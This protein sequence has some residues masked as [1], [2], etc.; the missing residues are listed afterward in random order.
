M[1]SA[2][3]LA[4]L[5]S[6]AEAMAAADPVAAMSWS[7]WQRDVLTD[8]H[9]FIAVRA[10]NQIGKT[11]LAAA[12]I[13]MEI[14]G[15]NPFRPPRHRGPL[16]ILLCSESYEQM[17]REGGVLEKLWEMLPKDEIDPKVS[18][19]RGKG[20][21]GVKYP[22]IRFI[23]GP[24]AGSVI[25][26]FRYEQGARKLAGSTLHGIVLDEPCPADIY[27]EAVP[28]LRQH[29]G[30]ML[31]TFTPTPDM[32]DQT[33]LRRLI[34]A[35]AVREHHIELTEAAC[36]PQG[37]ARPFQ[38]QA[39]IDAFAAHLEAHQVLLRVKAAWETIDPERYLTAW[40]EACVD[41]FE[42]RDLPPGALVGVGVDHGIQAGKQRA[43]LLVCADVETDAP[44][45]WLVDE[46]GSDD[47]T[48]TEQDAAAIKHMLD[49]HGL[50]YDDVDLW[51]G[52]R[53]AQDAHQ[54]KHKNNAALMRA[55]LRL[56]GRTADHP[57]AR[58]LATPKKWD[59]SVSDGFTFMNKA[60]KDARWRVH[61][62]CLMFRHAAATWRKA[63]MD[64]LK[65][66]LDPARYVMQHAVR[67]EVKIPALRA[68]Y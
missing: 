30:W 54:I 1:R 43:C 10:A 21:M 20:L 42:I 44:R 18:F 22:A 23:S 61:P 27:G 15:T 19:I 29:Q 52:D 36:W 9:R 51:V 6:E 2:L 50:D 28:R 37:Y 41:P 53:S 65:D 55:I 32:P 68:G 5:F 40:G 17:S 4:D 16:N 24:G 34:K 25:R 59:R 48:T 45:F 56:Y 49:R 38:S 63:Q 26:L 62:R 66:C 12:M 33:Y 14:R 13:I 35:G 31:I 7:A 60:M 8:L 46:A 47:P 67:N 64:P 3:A 11:M 58:T 39:Q 57:K